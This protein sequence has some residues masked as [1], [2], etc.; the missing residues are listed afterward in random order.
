V[1]RGIFTPLYIKSKKGVKKQPSNKK[2]LKIFNSSSSRVK[3][4]P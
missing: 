4:T 3:I 2:I 1:R